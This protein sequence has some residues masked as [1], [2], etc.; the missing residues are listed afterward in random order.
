MLFNKQLLK[1]NLRIKALS[2][3]F[4]AFAISIGF[5][6]CI[7]KT[8]TEN[9]PI[10][11][12]VKD[13]PFSF[14]K[15]GF[16][17]CNNQY[18]NGIALTDIRYS[19]FGID[20]TIF[21]IR[22]ISDSDT[23]EPNAIATP[24]EMSLLNNE[25]VIGQACFE[26]KKKFRLKG[27]YKPMI[28]LLDSTLIVNR[29]L[30]ITEK[31]ENVYHIENHNKF[32]VARYIITG[33]NA[34]IN[35]LKDQQIFCLTTLAGND[36]Y[37]IS[38][39]ATDSTWNSSSVNKKFE[40]CIKSSQDLFNNWLD[41]M[42]SL[43]GKY[44]K[45]RELAS[46]I[47]WSCVIDKGGN[48]KR[49]GILMSKNWM[50]Y[51][52]SWDHCFNAM[53][54]SY[55]MPKTAWDNYIILFDA[56]DENGQIPDV[57][58]Y[59]RT[60]TSYLKP[61]I[62]GW[63]LKKIMKKIE[64]N[65][66]QL[67]YAYNSLKKWTNFWF[68]H[69]DSN[70]NGIPEYSHGNDSGWD[71]GSEFDING[72]SFKRANRES[73]NLSAYLII[74]MDVL[75]DLALKLGYNVEAKQWQLRSDN[76][77]SL[78]ISN[79]WN[80][81]KFVTTNIDNGHINEKSQSLMAYL[82]I[83]LG[84]KLPSEIQSILINEMKNNGYLT[85]WGLATENINSPLYQDDGYWKGPIWAPSTMIIV[86]GLNKCG[87]HELATDIAKRFCDLCSKSGFAEN[88]NAKTGEGLRDL[89]YTW[90]ASVFLILGH[91]YLTD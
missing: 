5:Q 50:H 30:T 6:T 45:S 86:D 35:Y 28:L 11:F 79:T 40:D 82:P 26:S 4:F 36:D 91:E 67:E 31:S 77:L 33:L 87:E 89:S 29:K 58:G 75:H 71:N 51:I 18:T 76:L 49:P 32:G 13:S 73:A 81:K 42:P 78:M 59:S 12:K 24:G 56:Q 62:H 70:K 84:N 17:V 8:D 74:Q 63:A 9:K 55:K 27:W 46:Y 1:M 10:E 41:Q 88:F 34:S 60:I 47:L 65:I 66:P 7:K 68:D 48:Y 22:Y 80:G 61:P 20:N 3:P 25:N 90:T 83:I 52:W 38:V 72:E 2:I 19:D 53:A 54:C 37:E 57:H 14:P 21:K 44:K 39:E 43:P 64:L 69:R 23:I 85:Q 15:S 16:S